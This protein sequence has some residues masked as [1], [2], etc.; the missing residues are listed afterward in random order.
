MKNKTIEV[1]STEQSKDSKTLAEEIIKEINSARY[2]PEKYLTKVQNWKKHIKPKFNILHVNDRQVYIN[3]I[4]QC[5]EELIQYLTFVKSMPKF[6][7]YEPLFC[8]TYEFVNIITTHPYND[9]LIFKN[10]PDLE[11]RLKKNGIVFGVIAECIE[12][13]LDD[14]EAIVLKLLLDEKNDK[15]DRSILFNSYLRNIGV[16]CYVLNSEVT[17]TVL[18]FS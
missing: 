17:I 2:N 4:E 6:K 8:T 14:A 3:D 13:G 10:A 1:L 16:S 11:K 12:Y 18:N 15:M 7:Q 5:F 9:E